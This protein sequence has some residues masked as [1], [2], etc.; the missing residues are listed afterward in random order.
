MNTT[1][2]TLAAA[3]MAVTLA[4]PVV[5]Q[6]AGETMLLSAVRNEVTGMGFTEEQLDALSL[7]DLVSIATIVNSGDSQDTKKEKI[8]QVIEAAK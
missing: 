2:K 6:S 5:A 4:A 1:L 8:E 3:A 7:N